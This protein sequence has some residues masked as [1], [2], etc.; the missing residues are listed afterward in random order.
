MINLKCLM[1]NGAAAPHALVLIN[2]SSFD[3]KN[4]PKGLGL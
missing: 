3:I 2:N 1:F 4:Y